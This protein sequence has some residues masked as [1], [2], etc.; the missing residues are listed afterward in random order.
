MFDIWHSARRY[1]EPA[2]SSWLPARAQTVAGARIATIAESYPGVEVI[3]F[4]ATAR[5]A[6]RRRRSL[7]NFPPTSAR[8]HRQ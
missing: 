7:R 8:D 2:S 3:A 4:N 6:V 1:V 5:L